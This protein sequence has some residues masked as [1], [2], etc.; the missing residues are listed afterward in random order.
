MRD[1]SVTARDKVDYAPAVR[2]AINRIDRS[3][4]EAEKRLSQAKAGELFDQLVGDELLNGV[5][6]KGASVRPPALPGGG[7]L[8]AQRAFFAT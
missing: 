5:V 7:N 8:Y 3:P 4:V 6:C 1:Y 2:D